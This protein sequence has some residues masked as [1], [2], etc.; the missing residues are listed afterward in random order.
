MSNLLSSPKETG[1]NCWL[2]QRF[3][4]GRR[5]ANVMRCGY[6]DMAVCA[7]VREEIKYLCQRKITLAAE[8]DEK[9]RNIRERCA[10]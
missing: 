4:G 1:I 10:K 2:P 6:P 7:A 8:I 5:C 9:I 3:I